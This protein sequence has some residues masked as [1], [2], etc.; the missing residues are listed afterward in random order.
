MFNVSKLLNPG[1]FQEAI[2]RLN[3]RIYFEVKIILVECYEVQVNRNL[4]NVGHNKK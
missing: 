2:T 4:L 1:Q 3:D